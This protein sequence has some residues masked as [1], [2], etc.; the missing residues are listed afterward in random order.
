[1]NAHSQIASTATVPLWH[2]APHATIAITVPLVA[3]GL[4]VADI[5]AFVTVYR[6]ESDELEIGEMEVEGMKLNGFGATDSRCAPIK[7]TNNR[8]LPARA[9]VKTIGVYSAPEPRPTLEN[10]VAD[11]I[12][13]EFDTRHYQEVAN[14][15]LEKAERV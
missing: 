4:Y 5:E 8:Y 13:R 6:G 7:G 15:A 12:V 11:Q 1:M 2:T 3:A 14:E 9:E 10:F